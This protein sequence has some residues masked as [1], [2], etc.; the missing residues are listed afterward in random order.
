MKT[1]QTFNTASLWQKSETFARLC[2]PIEKIEYEELVARGDRPLQMEWEDQLKILMY[3]HLKGHESGRELLQELE[4][5]EWAK[6]AIAPK[7]GIKKS[8]F[9]EAL[10]HRGLKQ[11]EAIFLGLSQR[12]V[13]GL[14]TEYSEL[15][16]LVAIDASL[17][18]VVFSM[19]WAD[20]RRTEKKAKIQLA[21]DINRNIPRR[22]VIT[23]G[24]A[25]DKIYVNR[26]LEP[27]ETGI[28]DRFYQKHSDFDLWQQEGISFVCRI[29]ANTTKT[30][31][32]NN[33]IRSGSPI[34]FDALVLLGN[35]YINQTQQPVRLIGYRIGGSV[36]WIATNRF[37][38]TPEKIALIYKL[39]WDIENFFSWWKTSMDSY[40]PILARSPYGFSL[41]IFSSLVFYLLLALYC[42]FVLGVPVSVSAFR[43][44]RTKIT[45]ESRHFIASVSP[46]LSPP[47]TRCSWLL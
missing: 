32:Q 19:Q 14:P 5:D 3:F 26:L 20:Y 1:L 31:L 22:F 40:C 12:T 13:A 46:N 6:A 35:P 4:E 33:F 18:D 28:M 10:N 8:S 17:L 27:G 43:S 21:F 16:K 44:L 39:R 37:D 23:D 7:N 15:G 24:K 9:F 45:N 38:L 34:F 2:K 25:D 47:V 41:Q 36:F 42:L 29:R 11:M 30:I